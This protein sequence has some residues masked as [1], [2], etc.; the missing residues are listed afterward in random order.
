MPGWWDDSVFYEIYPRS[1]MD[2][3]GDGVG[4]LDGITDRIPYLCELGVHA[5]WLTP[6]YSSPGADCGYDVSDHSAIA[7][8]YGGEEAFDRL[9]A[10][11]HD[12]GLRVILDLVVSHTSIEH[13]W[14]T[15]HPDWYVWREGDAP[16]NNWIASF[17]GPAWTRDPAGPED[18]LTRW[19]LHS[20][21]PEQ[22]DL[23]WRNPEVRNAMGAMIR[24]WVQRGVDGFRVDAVDRL[25]KDP[26]L[27]DDP[28]AAEPFPLPVA[29]DQ[30]GL[31]LIHSRDNAEIG[32]ALQTLRE[33]AGDRPL[34]G[35]VYLPGPRLRPYLEHFDRVFA[36]D[37]LH[38]E[39]SAGALAAVIERIAGPEGRH[40]ALVT[41]NHDF[42]RVATRWGSTAVR[43]AAILLFTLPGP[44]FVYQGEEL[45]MADGPGVEPPIDRFGR[46]AF[47]HPMPWDDGSA[48]GFTTGTPWLPVTGAPGG[49][50]S[51]Q[52]K[53][54]GSVLSLVR[55]LTAVRSE[56][57]GGVEQVAERDGVVGFA[58]GTGHL[59]LLNLSGEPRAD[60]RLSGR[61]VLVA[62]EAGAVSG[63]V[64]AP[65][66]GV[67]LR[68]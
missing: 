38:A 23:D 44:A 8:E 10:A 11:A 57:G 66:A 21:F 39:W 3:D 40:L 65:A 37:L 9:V 15:E 32:L 24:G 28:P 63:G 49:P 1:F 30:Q 42:S 51:A 7:S 5:I 67:L 29:P 68:P 56:L 41:S 46:D 54:P 4:D 48:G 53:D 62:S 60:D 22:P 12:A 45:G 58:R 43:N 55:A 16:P 20:F 18:G 13:P 17:G 64:L 52:A 31:D 25:V 61:T 27:R 35:E 59:V 26:D 36:F 6:I 14:F 47:R 34:I 19:Y 50:A 2:S 33:A